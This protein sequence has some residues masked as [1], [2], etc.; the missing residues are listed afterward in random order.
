MGATVER[1]PK[2]LADL[3]PGIFL[4][5]NY[6][7]LD[8]EVDTSH[9]DYGNPIHAAN[10]LV[11]GAYLRPGMQTRSVVGGSFSG[12]YDELLSWIEKA[13]FIV[14]HNAKYELG[15]L[16]RLGV[17]LRKVFAFDTQIAEYVLL[18]NLAAGAKELGMSPLSTSLDQ[19]CRRRGLPIK[20]PVVDVLIGNGIN[21]VLIPQ[22]WLE[23]RCR[24]DVETTEQVFLDQRKDLQRRGLLPVQ[25]T[26]CLLTP[27]LA[28]IQF[29]GLALDADEVQKT[30]DDY[31]ARQVKLQ[32]DM[33]AFTGGI[34]VRSNKQLA[35]FVYDVLGFKELRTKRGEPKRSKPTNLHP[36]G[37]RK[38]DDKTLQLLKAT[39]AQQAEFLKLRKALGKVTSALSKNLAFFK[40]V[41]DEYEGTFHAE[42]HQ[43]VTA[44]HRLSSTGIPLLF[45]TLPTEKGEPSRKSVQFQNTPRGFKKLFRAK[46]KDFKIAEPDGSGL[47]FRIAV[48]LG[49]DEQGIKDIEDPKHDPHRF[50]AS[51]LN[52]ATIEQ[53][54]ENEKQAALG[55]VDSW[56]QLAK[57]DTFKPLYGGT[58]GTPEQERYYA[59]FRLRY[60]GIAEVQKSWLDSALVNKYVVTP[61][62]LVYYFPTAKVS[63]SGY[64]NVTSTV[65]NYPIQALATAEIIPIAL[66]YLWHGIRCRGLEEDVFIVNT[67]HDSAPCE[68]R[69]G[70]EEDFVSLAKQAFTT[71]VYNYLSRVYNMAFRVPLG[72]GIKIGERWGQ[73]PEMSFNI[74]PDGREVKVK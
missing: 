13:D 56:R 64:V 26:R 54:K 32:A 65:Y 58:K 34:N 21:P 73:G 22:P 30:Y 14:A 37:S 52:N 1:L 49:G 17:D 2:F 12:A 62:G 15:W 8:F 42:I 66:V 23:G 38:T 35:E 27:V 63:Q 10:D 4:S 48:Q 74:Y 28:D 20:D 59:A 69:V 31:I 29:E 7:V 5:D 45:K 57:P 41:V 3:D 50:T 61:W 70:K 43:T 25:Y 6:V 33:D 16:K 39:T 44:T 51:V 55:N 40:G 24:Q 9:G 46:R 18:G 36:G 47:E 71:D 11:M 53:V 68:V 72:V 19:C 60:P 67:V